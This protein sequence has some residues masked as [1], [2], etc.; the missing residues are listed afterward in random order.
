MKTF[1]LPLLAVL[2]QAYLAVAKVE[3]LEVEGD[4][5]ISDDGKTIKY[6]DPNCQPSAS[7]TC[8]ASRS[9]TGK[10]VWSLDTNQD[11]AA[12][13][14]PSQHLSG[15]PETE[16]FCCGKDHEVTG[17]VAVGYTCCP[18]GSTYDGQKCKQVCENGKQLKDGHCVCPKGTVEKDGTCKKTG[19]QPGECSSGLKTGKLPTPLT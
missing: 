12:C 17:S 11:H 18:T 16:F 15:S 19:C 13:C 10:K 4:V 6:T 1:Q 3:T 2:L 9:C 7:W 8:D 14:L 5:K